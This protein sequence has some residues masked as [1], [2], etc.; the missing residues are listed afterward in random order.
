M[1]PALPDAASMSRDQRRLRANRVRALEDIQP[2][3]ELEWFNSEPC[4]RH[5]SLNILCRRCGIRLRK[6]QRIGATW[7][8][9][10]LPGLLSDTMGSGKTA[11]ILAMLAMCKANGELGL[12]NR[13]VIVCRAAAVWDPWGNELK[14]LLPGIQAYVAD[15]DRE[16]RIRGYMGNWEIAVV[17][18][19]TLSGAHGK[20]Q[21]RDGDVA[22][23][24]AFPVG[25][26][27]YDD[28]DPMRNHLTETSAAV[29]RLAAQCTRVHGAHATPTQKQLKELWCFLQPVG[30]RVALG[31]LDY[32]ETKFTGPASRTI[33]TRDPSDK[34]GRR[35]VRKK[36]QLGSGGGITTDP[37]KAAEFRALIRDLV[38]RRTAKD[39]EGDVAM[40]AVQY[41]PV[42]LDLSPGQRSRYEELRRGTLRRLK[43]SSEVVTQ[44]E[45]A[46]AFT[47]GQ[48]I[49]SGLATLDEGPG[50]DDSVKLDWTMNLLAGDLSEEKAVVFVYFRN[51]V[52]ALA[53]RLQAEGVGAVLMWSGETG[54]R[55]RQRRLERFRE[56]PACRV[57]IG[58]TTIEA[59]L[60]LQVSRQV[61]AVD[62]IL[63]PARMSQLVG[64]CA[65]VGSQFPT[66]YVHHLL[67]R[68]TQ[69]D[70]YLPMLRR[71]G[72]I[73]DVVWDEQQSLF[74]ALSPRQIMRLVAFGKL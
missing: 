28:I 48:Q 18:D 62:T 30:G 3:P 20:R 22:L 36:V 35:R 34:T 68:G 7:M 73:A 69:E 59:S 61:I 47:R 66:V 39:I 10:G 33:L 65:R 52:A 5:E 11:Q 54:K 31:S 53:R 38:L 42:F 19:R 46:A 63:N 70:A 25:I 60:N 8:Y 24:E 49:C 14:R 2:F 15:G 13:A 9:L 6:H 17:S 32:F 57:L 45:A 56:D 74:T 67:A 58:T 55:E 16:Q 40:P 21:S 64:R 26:L 27:I 72:E 44:T 4:E 37:K 71:E 12:H 23:L 41:N 51:N 50:A 29:N 1:T 43:D